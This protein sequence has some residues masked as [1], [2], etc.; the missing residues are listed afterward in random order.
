MEREATLAR[1]EVRDQG[2]GIAAEDQARVFQ[3]FERA[4]PGSEY[5]GL[6]LGLY[7]AEQ[8]ATAHGGRI[9]VRSEPGQGARFT[10]ELPLQQKRRTV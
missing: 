1:L 8:I 3:R 10:V 4:A 5:T 7:F 9:S 2:R 6:G